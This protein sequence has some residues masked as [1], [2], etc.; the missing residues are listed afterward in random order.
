MYKVEDYPEIRDSYSLTG[1]MSGASRALSGNLL[2]LTC[3]MRRGKNDFKESTVNNYYSA[4]YEAANFLMEE[5]ANRG[6]E[7]SIKCMHFDVEIPKDA[8]PNDAFKLV[9]DFFHRNTMQEVQQYYE[10]RFNVDEAPIILA[11]DDSQRSFAYRQHAGGRAVDEVSVVFRERKQFSW[12]SIAHELLHQF[13]ATDLYFPDAL[14]ELA[15]HYLGNSIMHRDVRCIDDLTAY[16]IGWKDT[17][18]ANTYYFLK[19]TMWYT[20][21]EYRRAVAEAW[22]MAWN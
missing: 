8:N 19:D 9:R 18:S 1:R 4:A 2:L 12:F 14:A 10:E 5:A 13:G 7:L 16:L 6:V 20:E 15:D 11:F 21:E 22:K 3:F 17:I